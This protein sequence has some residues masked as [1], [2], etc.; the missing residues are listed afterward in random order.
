MVPQCPQMNGVVGTANVWVVRKRIVSEDMSYHH[1]GLVLR[2][3][4]RMRT[5]EL[6]DDITHLAAAQ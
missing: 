4:V 5:V 2:E 3:S 1:T 6:L